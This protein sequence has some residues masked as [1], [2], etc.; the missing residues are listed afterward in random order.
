MLF[1]N[2]RITLYSTDIYITLHFYPQIVLLGFWELSNKKRPV[3]QT[4]VQPGYDS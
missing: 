2:V 1:D 4:V 3:V